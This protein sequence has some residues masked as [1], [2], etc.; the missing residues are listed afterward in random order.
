[1]CTLKNNPYLEHPTCIT[2]SKKWDIKLQT[3]FLT[4][5]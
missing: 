5:C 4:V 1:M 2:S 3:D